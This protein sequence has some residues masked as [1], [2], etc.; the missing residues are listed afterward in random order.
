[1]PD[2]DKIYALYQKWV[3]RNLPLSKFAIVNYLRIAKNCLSY[4]DNFGISSLKDIEQGVFEEF[5]Y[6]TNG[7]RYSISHITLRKVALNHFFSWAYDNGYCYQNPVATVKINML[8]AKRSGLKTAEKNS[9][10]I[11]LSKREQALLLKKSVHNDFVSIRNKC[12]LTLALSSGLFAEEIIGLSIDNLNLKQG[13]V[14]IKGD[15]RRERRAV[16]DLSI[17]KKACGAWLSTRKKLLNNAHQKTST[18]FFT[19]QFKPL[20][21]RMLHLIIS[22]QMIDAGIAKERL[23]AE[24]LRQTAICNL[25]KRGLP[26]E[27]VQKYTGVK[28]LARLEEYRKAIISK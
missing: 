18:L 3:L 9:S 26:L 15:E 7:V 8:N 6:A 5:L 22:E 17:C 28:T 20:T 16:L 23:G 13:Y 2:F 10:I 21:R 27:E 25:F 11:F 12:I 19:Q 4:F 14:E 1:M 24:T